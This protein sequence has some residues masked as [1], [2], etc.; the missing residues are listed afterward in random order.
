MS[1][2]DNANTGSDKPQEQA[3]QQSTENP[4]VQV[5]Q[6]VSAPGSK[7]DKTDADVKAFNDS[8]M[9]P[10]IEITGVQANNDQLP[11]TGNHTDS[12][13][14]TENGKQINATY[15]P[16]TQ[17]LTYERADA[18]S[19]E[20][21]TV[22]ML[23]GKET[24]VIGSNPESK[25]D[26]STNGD[27]T[28][29]RNHAGG[30]V[31]S[32]EQNVNGKNV[33]LM[34][35]DGKPLPG[36]STDGNDLHNHPPDVQVNAEGKVQSYNTEAGVKVN[37]GDD[38]KPKSYNSN[39][40]TFE[41]HDDGDWYYHQDSGGE[42]VK[43]DEPTVASD[44][45]IHAKEN[46]GIRDGR[47]H[48]LDEQGENT[49]RRAVD[50]SDDPTNV[51]KNDEP[52]T[53]D[54]VLQSLDK[55]NKAFPENDGLRYFNELYTKI[56][57]ATKDGIE[58]G[59]FE[60]PAYVEKL[61]VNFANLYLDAIKANLNGDKMPDAWQALFDARNQ[62]GI[63]PIQFALA[64]VN[65]H[66]NH[67]LAYALVQT[68]K[69]MGVTPGEDSA[70]H[71]DFDKINDILG[72]S[73]DESLKLLGGGT[74]GELASKTGDIGQKFSL[75]GLKGARELAWETAEL[76][77]DGGLKAKAIA[78]VQEETSGALAEAILAA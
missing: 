66:I 65:A 52:K 16:D 35:P 68:N 24:T 78:A 13:Q 73:M 60:D 33:S 42:Y 10:S 23:S 67:D 76:L 14:M 22:D 40:F 44:G 3:S 4:W 57:Q 56:T 72:A 64:G 1:T 7:V 2:G 15:N 38:G 32:F 20:K 36:L 71:R 55:L 47:E 63:D 46:G 11:G 61:D 18:K 8:N 6:D 9:L 51:V 45:T 69:D 75:E 74:L 21:V 62:E 43:I 25:A 41:K 59:I 5:A 54:K 28:V 39:G 12:V 58:N 50:H 27:I 30:D 49:G 53:I 37:L 29:V 77:D 17:Q 48:S 31:T 70:Q 26:G 34:G 19:P